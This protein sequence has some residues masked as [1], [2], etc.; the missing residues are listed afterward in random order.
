MS[1]YACSSFSSDISFLFCSDLFTTSR[2]I[3]CPFL[4]QPGNPFNP[5][6]RSMNRELV[7]FSS[8]VH[9]FMT[10]RAIYSLIIRP[11][12]PFKS[13]KD[14]STL[15]ISR[16]ARMCLLITVRYICTHVTTLPEPVLSQC[17]QMQAVSRLLNKPTYHDKNQII[18]WEMASDSCCA[19]CCG[20]I[21]DMEKE[22]VARQPN[23]DVS[24]HITVTWSGPRH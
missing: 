20:R 24:D 7:H 4:T 6:S 14:C 15:L 12:S 1:V 16:L 5:S 18:V 22:I 9:I 17:E 2:I 23:I 11:C 3:S 10:S 13:T 19:A 21:Y 8:G